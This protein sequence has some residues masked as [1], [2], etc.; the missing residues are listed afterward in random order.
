MGLSVRR[1]GALACLLAPAAAHAQLAPVGVPAGKVRV[2]LDGRMDIWDSQYLDGTVVP[3]GADLTTDALRDETR[4]VFGLS[5]GLT[6]GIAIVGRVP[7][8]RSRAQSS[9]VTTPAAPASL[10][11]ALSGPV[12]LRPGGSTITFRGDAEA[13]AALTLVDHWDRGGH[14]GGFRAAVEGL[15]R[16]PTGRVPQ[17]DRLF[18]V[19]T[20]DGQTDLE[21]RVTAD[22]GAGNLGIRL[23]GDYNRQLAA[24]MTAWV[25]DPSQPPTGFLT[26]VRNDPGDITTLAAR[27]FYRLARTLAIQGSAVYWSRGADDVTWATPA[28]E[29]AGVDPGVL[30]A[31][32]K[33]NATVLGIGLTYANPGALRQ[34]GR[35]LP[36]D[37]GWS[38]A[39]VVKSSA[40]RVPN[41]HSISARFRFYFG[42]F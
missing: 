34:G 21:G 11:S 23:E 39:R 12:G 25:A 10:L 37:A 9:I 33:A 16:L 32:T 3:L 22:F 15:V 1:L 19:G 5:I 28:D 2:E 13:G 42:L 35:G 40:G 41:R 30:A 26:N 36:M 7:L 6:N 20:G 27:P 24:D 31:D 4:G 17:A 8:V 18:P 14:R 29:I 38:Y